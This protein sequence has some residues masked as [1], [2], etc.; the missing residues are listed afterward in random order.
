MK[1]M[2]LIALGMI[3]LMAICATLLTNSL[4]S[5]VGKIESKVG[6]KLILEKDTVMIIDYSLLKNSYTLSNGKEISFELVD[7]LPVVE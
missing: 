4:K 2:I 1:K 6:T 5:E 7:K 3:F